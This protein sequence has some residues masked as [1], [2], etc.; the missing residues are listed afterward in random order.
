MDQPLHR[1][2]SDTTNPNTSA[3]IA[4]YITD[5]IGCQAKVEGNQ[6]YNGTSLCRTKAQLLALRD[7]TNTLQE[8]NGNEI[9]DMAGCLSACSKDHYREFHHLADLC[10]VDFDLGIVVNRKGLS[11]AFQPKILAEILQKDFL[12]IRN[13]PSVFL[14]KETVSAEKTFLHK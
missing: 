13:V 6:H 8:A 11:V 12:L 5:K 2:T 14:R 4:S 9:Y 7:M 3:C 1:C 10:W